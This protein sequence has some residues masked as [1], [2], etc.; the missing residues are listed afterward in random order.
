M[1]DGQM[2]NDNKRGIDKMNE[3]LFPRETIRG[4]KEIYRRELFLR[5]GKYRFTR[6]HCVI[7]IKSYTIYERQLIGSNIHHL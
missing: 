2:G 5:Y 1:S 7:S 4:W 3:P 6:I